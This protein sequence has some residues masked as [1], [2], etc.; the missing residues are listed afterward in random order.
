MPAYGGA[1]AVGEN[2]LEQLKT[3][4]DFTVYSVSS[5]TH[6]K[7]GQY[8]G[9]RQIVFKKTPIKKLNTL[10]YYIQSCFHALF[11]ANYDL[12]HMH[13]RDAAFLLLFLRMK[14]KIIL[15]THGTFSYNEKWSKF[16]WYIHANVKYFV[17]Y[18]NIITCVSLEEK[19][20]FK[21]KLN[22]EA[23]HIPNGINICESGSKK[24]DADIFQNKPFLFFG[25]GRIIKTKGLDI[26]LSALKMLNFS[27]NLLVAGDLEQLPLYKQEILESSKSLK[28]KFLGLVKDKELLFSYIENAQIFIF[29]SRSEAMSMMLLEAVGKRAKIICSDITQ[30]KDIFLSNE[31]VFF[32]NGDANDLKEKIAFALDNPHILEKNS[33]RAYERLINELNWGAISKKYSEVYNTLLRY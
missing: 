11:K 10:I 3:M 6:L 5:H 8:K 17:K 9:Y 28:V 7:T 32:K 29:P 19:R 23:V 33:E 20:V 1:A 31:T 24:F 4:Y 27:G 12:I 30:N 26:L 22:L 2:I 18:A 13:H 15:T 14:Y 21:S 25:A 16:K